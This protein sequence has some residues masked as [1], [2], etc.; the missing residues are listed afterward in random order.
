MASISP[1]RVWIFAPDKI[2]DAVL[3]ILNNSRGL[4]SRTGS[5]TGSV[6]VI[7][8]SSDLLNRLSTQLKDLAL[9][10][11]LDY[12]CCSISAPTWP[13]TPYYLDTDAVPR[14]AFK[15][16]WDSPPRAMFSW[17]LYRGAEAI[18]MKAEYVWECQQWRN[19]S[20]ATR[21]VSDAE[22]LE[23]QT[24]RNLRVG[25]WV[26]CSVHDRREGVPNAN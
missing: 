16:S 9:E 26:S 25:Q 19:D 15:T 11:N 18:L 17:W 2:R 20:Q 8:P 10:G 21:A 22:F 14:L 5:C 12:P 1:D 3:T 6:V 7:N 4:I 24:E 23:A 13:N